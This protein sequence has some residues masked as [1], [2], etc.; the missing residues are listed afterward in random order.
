MECTELGNA[1]PNKKTKK[2]IIKEEAE[3]E[4]VGAMTKEKG[5]VPWLGEDIGEGE[6]GMSLAGKV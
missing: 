5:R 3:M 4:R 6:R 2:Y 1:Q